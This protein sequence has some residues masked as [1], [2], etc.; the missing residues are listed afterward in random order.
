MMIGLP[1]RLWTRSNSSRGNPG[2]NVTTT[3]VATITAT[4]GGKLTS[5]KIESEFAGTLTVPLTDPNNA[6]LVT[7]TNVASQAGGTLAPVFGADESRNT[8]HYSGASKLIRSR[9]W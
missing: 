8:A 1:H 3:G 9:T 6:E 5:W 4:A 2:L 7:L